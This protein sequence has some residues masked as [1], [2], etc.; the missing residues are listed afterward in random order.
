MTRFN[1]FFLFVLLLIF[2]SAVAQGFR[3]HEVKKGESLEQIANHYQ[4]S[5]DEIYKLNPDAKKRNINHM[6]LV[7]PAQEPKVKL[8]EESK[9]LSFKS[10]QI[11]AKE[12]LY[13]IAKANHLSIDELK[14]YNPDLVETDIA[15]G[16]TIKIP[17]FRKDKRTPNFNESLTNSSFS[18]IIHIVLPGETKYRIAKQYGLSVEQ[19]QAL[20]PTLL[21]LKAGQLLTIVNKN[22]EALTNK[23]EA[24]LNF[25]NYEVKPKET[26]FRLTKM[27]NVPADSLYAW[28]PQLKQS[29][30]KEGMQI[31]LP[32]KVNVQVAGLSTDKVNLAENISDYS[33]QK[34]AVM[35][36]LSLD[37]IN[38]GN[39]ADVLKKDK[40]LR[41]ALDFYSGVEA[42]IRKAEL[43]GITVEAKVY[44]T[45]RNSQ[46]VASIINNN[47]FDQ[48][49]FVVGPFFTKTVETASKLLESKKI[50]VLS[51]ISSGEINGGV[52]LI[53][54]RPTDIMMQQSIISFIKLHGADKNVVV[55]ADK[56]KGY[57]ESK[58]LYTLPEAK[59]VN[60]QK[61]Y[62]QQS[63]LARVLDKNR[64]NWFILESDDM[65]TVSNAASYLN[66]LR[67]TFD[68]QLFTS[69]KNDLYDSEVPS[70][71]LGNLNF[72]YAA[73]NKEY[74]QDPLDEFVKIYREDYGLSPNQYV[75]RGYD[76]TLDAILRKANFSD[77][78]ES[79]SLDQTTEYVENQFNYNKKLI[80]GYFNNAVYI[81]QYNKELQIQSVEN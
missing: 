31:K 75:I 28:N 46:K 71:Y 49:D 80:G 69:N 43:L 61:E 2:P 24:P 42:A 60:L 3:T 79:L 34:V 44:D 22:K 4:V 39:K 56:G 55:L 25:F 7:I 8:N 27:F 53:Q 23:N 64:T 13:S 1:M 81:L 52:N 63:D 30:L 11:Q 5:V 38:D 65:A 15:I 17:I 18:N 9:Q 51:P 19:L 12:T 35:L 59:L 37:N 62:L 73:I 14:Q 54:T 66:T 6:V 57:L 45:Q 50:P 77:F 48:V 58:I 20:N 41:I 33:T 29:G 72:T 74:N 40:V 16:Q 76:V 36:P 32:K 78:Y 68:I 47:D 21:D 67:S 70:T 26:I 10:Y